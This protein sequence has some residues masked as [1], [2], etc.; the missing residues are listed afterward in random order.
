[1]KK[2]WKHHLEMEIEH[3]KIAD[4]LLQKHENKKAKDLLPKELPELIK[5]QSNKEY[6]RDILKKEV[7]LTANVDEF[8]DV[9]E[10]DTDHRFYTYQKAVNSDPVP[11]SK[12]ILDHMDKK[13]QDYR[14]TSEGKHPVKELASRK[15]LDED[16]ARK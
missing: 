11:S 9:S 3:L 8:L 5:F 12:V 16:V 15:K 7:N 10:L 4:K 14:F 2:I 1:M 6:V 13:E